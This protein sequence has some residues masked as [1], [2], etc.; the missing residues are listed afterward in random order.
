MAY[1]K[2][3]HNGKPAKLEVFGKNHKL[4]RSLPVHKEAIDLGLRVPK[5]YSVEEKQ[6]KIYKVTEWVEGNTIHDE[7]EMDPNTIEIICGDL[8]GYVNELFDTNCIAAVDNHFKNFVWNNNSVVYIDLKKLLHEVYDEHIMRMSKICLKNC[9]GEYK[10][11]KVLAFLKGYSKSGNVDHVIAACDARNW[12]WESRRSIDP[13]K[14]EEI[15]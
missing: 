10:R 1:R 14:L 15:I 7:M 8:A 6:G 11:R 2:I 4:F 3:S 12:S 9:R 13:I 5:L